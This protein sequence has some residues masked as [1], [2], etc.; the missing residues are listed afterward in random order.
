[1]KRLKKARKML[2]KGW[3]IA[4]KGNEKIVKRLEKGWKRA[5]KGLERLERGY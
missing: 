4:G 3:K 2:E 1:M 5:G